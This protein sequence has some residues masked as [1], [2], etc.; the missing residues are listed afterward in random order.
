[1]LSAKQLEAAGEHDAAERSYTHALDLSPDSSGKTRKHAHT[2]RGKTDPDKDAF[3]ADVLAAY[4][5]FLQNIRGDYDRAESLFKLSLKSN[6]T[7]LDTLQYYAIFLEER[8]VMWV[9]LC[10]HTYASVFAC[11]VLFRKS[12]RDQCKVCLLCYCDFFFEERYS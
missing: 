12:D 3:P 2:K 10:L 8:C 7:H 11:S 6:P 4:G 1:V 5:L 9:W